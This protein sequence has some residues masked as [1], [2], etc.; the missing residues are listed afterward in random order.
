[1]S[2]RIVHNTDCTSAGTLN[3]FKPRPCYY[4]R[5]CHAIIPTLEVEWTECQLL[6]HLKTQPWSLRKQ[7]CSARAFGES[8]AFCERLAQSDSPRI[9]SENGLLTLF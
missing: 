5:S 8:L 6:F 3:I 2:S 9:A 7:T 4:V 1:M